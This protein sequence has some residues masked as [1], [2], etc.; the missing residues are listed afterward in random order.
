M[1]IVE[2][3][4]IRCVDRMKA[5]HHLCTN[6]RRIYNVFFCVE[7][8]YR[9]DTCAHNDCSPY[10]ESSPTPIFCFDCEYIGMD[11]TK[12][13]PYKVDWSCTTYDPVVSIIAKLFHIPLDKVL[14]ADKYNNND[15]YHLVHIQ[16][17][18]YQLNVVCYKS[19]IWLQ[20]HNILCLLLTFDIDATIQEILTFIQYNDEQILPTDLTFLDQPI[21]MGSV[22]PL[23]ITVTIQRT[24]ELKVG[25]LSIFD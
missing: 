12:L 4:S 24:D 19:R 11:V 14:T 10:D 9:N 1:S 2:E 16:I 6:C 18:Q 21:S 15:L 23:I 3:M 20:I 5:T 7:Y 8:N 25:D 17:S 22:E 13:F